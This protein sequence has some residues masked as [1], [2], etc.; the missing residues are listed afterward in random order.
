MTSAASGP[1][2]AAGEDAWL[3]SATR[4]RVVSVQAA[5]PICLTAFASNVQ[6]MQRCETNPSCWGD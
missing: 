3:V 4:G 5:H 1:E 6:K 2:A